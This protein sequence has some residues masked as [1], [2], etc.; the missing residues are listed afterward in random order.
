MSNL[1]LPPVSFRP[2]TD[3]KDDCRNYNVQ[4][5]DL[6]NLQGRLTRYDDALKLYN[7]FDGQRGYVE[8]I[9]KVFHEVFEKLQPL[10]DGCAEGEFRRFFHNNLGKIYDQLDQQKYSELAVLARTGGD[11]KI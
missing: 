8:N 2:A 7:D 5:S 4:D 1:S 11:E 3:F 9:D 6:A 10:Y